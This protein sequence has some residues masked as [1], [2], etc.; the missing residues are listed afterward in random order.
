MKSF[1]AIMLVATLTLSVA[2]S[3][4]PLNN[5][6]K[7]GVA[8]KGYDPV[9][10]FEEGGGEPTKGEKSITAEHDGATYRFATEEHRELFTED[11]EKF[12]PAYG[13]W[14]AYAMAEGEK[15]EIDPKSYEI[16]DGR[17]FVFYKDWFNNTLDKWQGERDE[18]LPKADGN[19]EEIA[20]EESDD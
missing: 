16:H 18:L 10:Y 4:E 3:A 19:W 14:C 20:G 13:G 17:L 8:L 9:A 11:P 12:A 1:S 15:V 5:V 2:A 7:K 6:D